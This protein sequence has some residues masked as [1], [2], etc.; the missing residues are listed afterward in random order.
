MALTLE[1]LRSGWRIINDRLDKLA[2]QLDKLVE[3]SKIMDER[4]NRMAE[5]LN[6][7]DERD[8]IDGN[9][10]KLSAKQIRGN[11]YQIIDFRTG[12]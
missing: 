6:I 5:E 9:V 2:V 7:M 3:Q 12:K 10:A 1:E 8:L 4:L 11:F